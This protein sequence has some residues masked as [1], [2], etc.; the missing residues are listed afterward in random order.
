MTTTDTIDD[1]SNDVGSIDYTNE[2]LL[3]EFYKARTHLLELLQQRLGGNNTMIDQFMNRLHYILEIVGATTDDWL[4]IK[5]RLVVC[6][7]KK[8]QGRRLF[9]K[10]R[11]DHRSFYNDLELAVIDYWTSITGVRPF[12]RASHFCL[13]DQPKK[14]QYYAIFE[15]NARASAALLERKRQ[16]DLVPVEETRSKPSKKKNNGKKRKK[17][18]QT[19]ISPS[20]RAVRERAG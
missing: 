10:R 9:T 16:K 18:R 3:V 13:P 14:K 20:R 7:G 2:Q 11:S 5:R 17:Q 4:A 8:L 6:I 19:T 1:T 15:H 12:I